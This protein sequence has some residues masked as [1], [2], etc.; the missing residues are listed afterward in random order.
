MYDGSLTL[1]ETLFCDDGQL[2]V[3][4]ALAELRAGRPIVVEAPD[5]PQIMA[6]F[7]AIAPS[8]LEAFARLGNGALPRGLRYRASDPESFWMLL[9]SDA[10]RGRSWRASSRRRLPCQGA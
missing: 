8:V 6:A 9:V 3:D 4:R 10:T 2:A 5:G 7:D 1:F